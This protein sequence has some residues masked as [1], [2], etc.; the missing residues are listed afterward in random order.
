MR[1]TINDVSAS[2]CRL[3]HVL[4]LR[5]NFAAGILRTV[6]TAPSSADTLWQDAAVRILRSC[7]VPQSPIIK[8]PGL[9]GTSDGTLMKSKA[10][11]K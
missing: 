7:L 8:Q 5:F 6:A 9:K 10:S 4:L 3:L 2:L 1:D 11:R